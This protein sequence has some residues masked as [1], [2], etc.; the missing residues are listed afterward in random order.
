LGKLIFYSI[1]VN[2]FFALVTVTAELQMW[3]RG[4]NGRSQ[5]SLLSPVPPSKW[6]LG[7]LLSMMTL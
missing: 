2:S 7:L 4:A 5:T 6:N 1:T 3:S